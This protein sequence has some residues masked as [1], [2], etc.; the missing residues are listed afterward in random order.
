MLSEIVWLLMSIFVDLVLINEAQ[1]T[2]NLICKAPV[3]VRVY[4]PR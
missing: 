4:L 1:S 2:F 3:T